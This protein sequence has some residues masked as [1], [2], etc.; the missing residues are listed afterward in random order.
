MF[1]TGLRIHELLNMR[2]EDIRGN[3]IFTIGKGR[4]EGWVYISKTT[5]KRLKLWLQES[6]ATDYIW[7]K[8]TRRQYYQ[9]YTVAG[10]RSRLAEAFK[11]AGFNDFQPHELRHSF[12]TDLRRR[13]ADI[14]VIQKLLRHSNLSSTQRYLHNLDGDLDKVW[15]SF[16][17]YEL[18]YDMNK[19][20]KIF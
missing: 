1:D 19:K 16:K 12:A 15:A 9:R 20:T 14:D 10:F 5:S 11:K 8:C 13:G 17:N 7:I 18:T 6:H 3:K 4:K 2:V